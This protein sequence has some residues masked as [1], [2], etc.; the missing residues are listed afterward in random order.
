MPRDQK[1]NLVQF[2]GTMLIEIATTTVPMTTQ[3]GDNNKDHA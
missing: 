1:Q 3:E 2:I